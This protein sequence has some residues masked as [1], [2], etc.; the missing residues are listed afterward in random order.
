VALVTNRTP[1]DLVEQARSFGCNLD[2]FLRKGQALVFEY[3]ETIEDEVATLEDH[4]RMVEE[5]R[6]LIGERPVT[7]LVFDPVNP[8]AAVAGRL[9]PERC[10]AVLRA[11]SNLKASALFVVE[12]S[13]ED[14]LDSF[15]DAVGGM[16]ALTAPSGGAPGELTVEGAGWDSQ[17]EPVRFEIQLGAGLVEAPDL[18]PKLLQPWSEPREIAVR[19]ST[20]EVYDDGCENSTLRLLT[21]LSSA[22]GAAS[23][24][25]V[26]P[27]GSPTGGESGPRVLLIEPDATRRLTL[28][29]HLEKNFVVLESAGVNE[30]MTL[31]SIGRPDAIL[32]AMEMAGVSGV[33]VAR[34]LRE[35]GDNTLLIGLGEIFR[36]APEQIG[37]LAAG[38]DLCFGYSSD[39][40]ILRLTLLNLMQRIGIVR[41]GQARAEAVRMVRPEEPEPHSCTT[42]LG[43]FC[44]RIARETLYARENGL[45]FV[46]L[47]FRL[48]DVP[49]AVEELASFTAMQIRSYDSVFAGSNGVACLLAEADSPQMFLHRFWNHWKGG[50]SPVVEELR[51]LNQDA[52]LQRAREFVTS[53]VGVRSTARKAG[54]FA[55]AAGRGRV[56]MASGERYPAIHT[57]EE[58]A[59]AK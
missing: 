38:V 20:R 10:R 29:S 6:G 13:W 7:R 21:T 14:V 54:A 57:W 55:T 5:F 8:L 36:R 41:R 49:A 43:A 45:S 32:V 47:T 40:R 11:F 56:A 30:A 44:G 34:M 58:G 9:D 27:P 33:E 24:Q 19:E 18:K 4:T 59:A 15:V 37:A 23:G 50:F 51:F 48:P 2:T 17:P 22:D 3:P 28:R 53:R 42:D 52:F 31:M 12:G 25:P 35:K 46:I 1:A 26:R 39:P 16:I